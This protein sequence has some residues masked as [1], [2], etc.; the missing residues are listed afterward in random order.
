[1]PFFCMLSQ[2]NG[3]CVAEG[4]SSTYKEFMYQ[5]VQICTNNTSGIPAYFVL[6]YTRVELVGLQE[7]YKVDGAGEKY[8]SYAVSA[9]GF[10]FC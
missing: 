5:L 6:N 3:T 7:K 9:Q 2:Q 10:A 8:A 1:M 4:F